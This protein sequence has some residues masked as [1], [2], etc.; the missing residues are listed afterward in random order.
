M[1]EKY[2]APIQQLLAKA[3]FIDP[4][5]PQYKLKEKLMEEVMDVSEEH[6]NDGKSVEGVSAPNPPEKTDLADLLHKRKER[7][8]TLTPKGIRVGTEVIGNFEEETLDSRPD[9]LVSNHAG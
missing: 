7:I 6:H 4:Q 2:K 1:I 8:S 9:P 3:T 5:Y